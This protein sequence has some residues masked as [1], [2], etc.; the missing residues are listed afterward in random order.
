M[1]SFV[2]MATLEASMSLHGRYQIGALIVRG[3]KIL[4]RGCNQTKSDPMVVRLCAYAVGRK[5]KLKNKLHAEMRALKG[6][7][8]EGA[9][10]SVVRITKAFELGLSKPCA[11]CMRM[12]REAGVKKIVYSCDG[13]M[14]SERL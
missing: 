4:S 6:I 14:N 7:D 3:G 12:L 9:A 5:D 8:A 10:A 2:R 1:N 13:Y 11:M